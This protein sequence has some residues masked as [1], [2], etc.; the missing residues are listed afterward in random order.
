MGEKLFQTRTVPSNQQVVDSRLKPT[1]EMHILIGG[2]YTL[3]GEEHRYGH[4]AL[5]IKVGGVDVTYDFGRYGETRGLFGEAG[6]GILRVWS[7]FNAYI[8]AEN[9]LG[10]KTIGFVYSLFEHQ[11]KASI[12][13]FDQLI[14]AGKP[15]PHKNRANLKVCKL[16]NDYHALGPNCTTLSVDGARAA[17]PAIDRNAE[18]FI[19]PE[20]VLSNSERFAL[21]AKGGANRLFL[22]V[23]L[24]SLLASGSP[25][26]AI[27]VDQHG[28]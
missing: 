8:G 19:K 14:L 27:R 4:T 16:V 10:R 26:K 2:P 20:A 23:N 24:Q 13:F 11:A 17:L 15:L 12:A 1:A 25:V 28:G 9:R 5:R 21:A 22:P 7:D 18:K 6:D 3:A